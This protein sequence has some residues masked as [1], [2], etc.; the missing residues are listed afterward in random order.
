MRSYSEFAHERARPFSHWYFTFLLTVPFIAAILIGSLCFSHQALYLLAVPLLVTGAW[1]MVRWPD[2][3]AVVSIGLLYSNLPVVAVKFHGAPSFL[4]A[5]SI[6]LMIWPLVHRVLIQRE[7][8]RLLHSFPWIVMLVL[9]HGVGAVLSTD[10]S[11]SLSQFAAFLIEGVG[12]YLLVVNVVRT[13]KVALLCF[14]AFSVCA[15]LMGSIPMIQQAT[16]TLDFDYGGLAQL[17]GVFTTED[18]EAG[19]DVTQRRS[20]GTIGEQNR[21]AQFMLMLVPICMALLSQPRPRWIQALGAIGCACAFAGFS[22]AFSRGAAIGLV[23]TMAIAVMLGLVTK[24]QLKF[25]ALFGL[26]ACLA[27]PNY[28]E[29]VSSVVGLGGITAQTPGGI[30]E[31]DGAVRGRLTEMLGAILAFRDQ[32]LFGV[33]PGMF[34]K[35]SQAYGQIIG[36]RPLPEG[37]QAHSLPLDIAAENGILGLIS[38]TMVFAVVL[39]ALFRAKTHAG[40][41]GDRLGASLSTAMFV[42]LTLYLTTSAFLHLSYIR[43]VWM[44]IGLSEAIAFLVIKGDSSRSYLPPLALLGDAIS[45]SSLNPWKPR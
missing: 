36:L 4:P 12:V 15:I 40:T 24:T 41:S 9:V 28:V 18:M 25:L 14:L 39:Q 8:I 21:Y 32:P 23:A 38:M 20:S 42:T 17:D 5:A 34:Q 10:P 45:S 27:L 43:Y 30:V 26:L 31:S 13:R 29:R 2:L 7:P 44:V 37:R 33:G 3:A 6:A 22:L 11:Y 35:H 1:L 16:G 19:E